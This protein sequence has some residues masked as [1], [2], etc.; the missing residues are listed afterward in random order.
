MYRI[1]VLLVL[2][3]LAHGSD[4]AT[5]APGPFNAVQNPGTPAFTADGTTVYFNGGR[6]E[7]GDRTPH[8]VLMV[9]HLR[10][11]EWTAP[12]W[13]DFSGLTQEGNPVLSPDGKR[14]YF[15]SYR[16]QGEVIQQE[17]AESDIWVVE[18]D[19]AGWGVPR[20]LA[21]PVNSDARDYTGSVAA[22]GTFYFASSRDGGKGKNDIYVAHPSSGGFASVEN[23]GDVINSSENDLTPA[24][25]PDGQTLVFWSDRP[26]GLGSADLYVSFRR[27]GKWQPAKN[28]GNVVNTVYPEANALFSP[29]GKY[30]YFTSERGGKGQVYQ[31]EASLLAE[32]AAQE[33]HP[34][35]V[36][37][38]M[39]KPERFM[40]G[41]ISTPEQGCLAFSPDGKTIVL[42][43]HTPRPSRLMVSHFENGQWSKPEVAPFSGTEYADGD[44]VFTPNGRLL[45]STSRL[46][47]GSKPPGGGGIWYVELSP[48]G[49]GEPKPMPGDAN[50]W[51]GS[52]ASATSGGT[53]Y[54]FGGWQNNAELSRVAFSDGQYG[55]RENL[56]EIVNS[57]QNDVDPFVARD[58]SFLLF[59][60]NRPG[61]I[62]Q[63]DMYVSHSKDGHWGAPRSLGPVVNG[64]EGGQVCPRV[65]PDGR[66]F[67][68][69][70]KRDGREGIFQIDISALEL[71]K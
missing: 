19:G 58:G 13:L 55:P 62:G 35:A 46:L 32:L 57:R 6:P 45:F 41:V 11:G 43:K 16:T 24:V 9:S 14:M 31:I 68:F 22:D 59:S 54:L 63:M 2:A 10:G 25:S 70:G 4:R 8:G 29:D 65:S 60:S 36:A 20:K 1:I 52:H 33:P 47:N 49:W 3:T 21:A 67:L 18:K 30:L 56:G 27:D 44:P 5:L 66:Y 7:H 17:K 48:R 69:S 12:A 34:Y 37:R 42:A 23:L 15:W 53:V 26:G 50:K 61:G 71:G 64:S 38:P 28:L 51:F 39:P 40:E